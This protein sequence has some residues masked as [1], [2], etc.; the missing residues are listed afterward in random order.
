MWMVIV[1]NLRIA[2]CKKGLRHQGLYRSSERTG[3]ELHCAAYFSIS[4][5]ILRVAIAAHK[6]AIR[7]MRSL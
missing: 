2:L 1:L 6:L 7:V 4:V 3:S 5:R